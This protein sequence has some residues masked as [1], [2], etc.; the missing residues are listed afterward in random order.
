VNT[1]MTFEK[2]NLANRVHVARDDEEKLDFLVRRERTLGLYRL[3]F[4]EPRL[5]PGSGISES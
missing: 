5:R 4:D 3:L 1:A 2:R